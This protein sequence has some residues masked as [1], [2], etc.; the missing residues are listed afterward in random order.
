M[1]STRTYGDQRVAPSPLPGA[2]VAD[3]APEAAFGVPSNVDLSGLASSVTEMANQAKARADQVAV[4]AADA[5][6]VRAKTAALWDPQQGAMNARGKDA[7]PASDAAQQG[8]RTV[9]DGIVQG[10]ANDQQKRAVQDRVNMHYSDLWAALEQHV[11]TQLKQYDDETTQGHVDALAEAANASYLDDHTVQSS[12]DNTRAVLTDYFRR[13]GHGA[14]D[15]VDDYAQAQIANRV[16]SIRS[17]VFGQLSNDGQDLAA[18]KYFTDHRDE[19]TGRDLVTA[20]HV[21]DAGSTRAAGMQ[22]ASD[23]LQTNA[24]LAAAMTAVAK[25]AEPKVQDDAARR[26]RQAFADQQSDLTQQRA[27]AFQQASAI[28]ESTKGDEDQIPLSIR[29]LLSP[30]ENASLSS[31]ADHLR[32]PKR[33]TDPDTFSNLMNMAG[34]PQSRPAFL[35]LNLLPYRDQLSDQDYNKLVNLQLS[36]NVAEINKDDTRAHSDALHDR[37]LAEAAAKKA[38]ADA[39]TANKAAWKKYDTDLQV[40]NL[41]HAPGAP[42]PKKP[43]A[44]RPGTTPAP[45]APITVP[46]GAPPKKP[47]T[48]SMV[49]QSWLDHAQNTPDYADYLTHMG[50]AVGGDE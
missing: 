7:I 25:I 27:Q 31:R 42:P 4:S 5:Q 12:I 46:P 36:G 28:V 43:L 47:P 6:L 32:N 34:M 15:G 41:F 26:V 45:G 8:F 33:E 10:L 49:P 19:F 48:T 23:I 20:E 21:A 18:A 44:A 22:A 40:Y 50:V 17:G 2:R 39:V 38:A 11:G 13:N 30:E 14:G 24:T 1:A 35:K 9:A 29:T 16:S 3:T 37:S